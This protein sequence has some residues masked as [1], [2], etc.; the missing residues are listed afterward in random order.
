MVPSRK[1]FSQ[2]LTIKGFLNLQSIS[3]A[4]SQQQMQKKEDFKN[5]DI[6]CL[7]VPFDLFILQ[8]SNEDLLC[9]TMSLPRDTMNYIP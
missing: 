3:I 4:N 1:Q 7:N 9:T 5:L 6:E 8:R 2:T